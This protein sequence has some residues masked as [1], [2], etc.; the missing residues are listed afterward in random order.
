MPSRSSKHPPWSSSG[1]SV[2]SKLPAASALSP[3]YSPN[4][5]PKNSS[6]DA[7][8]TG[9]SPRRRPT[10]SMPRSTPTMAARISS[11]SSIAS[12]SSAP[13]FVSLLTPR[14]RSST[15][16]SRRLTL[17]KSK[18]TA[19]PTPRPRSTLPNLSSRRKSPSTRYSPRMKIST[20]SALPRV[21]ATK[22]SPPVGA[23]PVSPARP[24]AVF[25]RLPAS[26][27]G[28]PPEYR[29]P[30]PVPVRTAT[31]TVPK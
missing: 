4:T 3:P 21:R 17:W 12:P 10:P 22:E 19:A 29:A 9:T 6:A 13:S 18:S 30:S 28:I 5:C 1:S 31:S 11:T 26:V 14:L 15:S 20:S 16:A 27:P 8:R 2:T 23:S 7:T 24:T 25:A